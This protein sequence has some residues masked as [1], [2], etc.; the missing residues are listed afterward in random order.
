MTDPLLAEL[1]ALFDE[2]DPVPDLPDVAPIGFE[3]MEPLLEAVRGTQHLAFHHGSVRVHLQV[4]GGRLTGLV[5]P[6]ALVR[7]HRLSG[8]TDHRAD[9]EGWFHAEVAAGPLCVSLPDEGVT[10]D[11]FVA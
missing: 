10:T 1:R 5:P 11:W 2:V 4:E 6:D 9:A 3:P 8:T 7:V